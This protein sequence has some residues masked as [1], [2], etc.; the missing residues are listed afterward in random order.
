MS[1]ILKDPLLRL[2]PMQTADLDAVMALEEAVYP[3]P[4]TRGIFRD[5]LQ[6]G[7]CCWVYF[8]DQRL[9]GY[10]VMSV[11]AGEAHILNLCIHPE[12]RRQGLGK[13]LLQRLLDLARKHQADTV[14]LEVR[15][16]NMAAYKLYLGQ[17]FN[18]VGM[19]RGY[20]PAHG[21]REDAIIL[22]C[23]LSSL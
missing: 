7:Y 21:G 18:E 20:Y 14:F 9:I 13:Q 22:A 3:F 15:A 16:S 2:R 4:W 12:L 11:G 6:A 10:A 17:G 23:V 1:A 5:C 19:R 8:M